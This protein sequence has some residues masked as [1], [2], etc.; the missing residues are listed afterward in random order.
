VLLVE[1]VSVKFSLVPRVRF[2][3]R[4]NLT[5]MLQVEQLDCG[6]VSVQF[7]SCRSSVWSIL[8]AGDDAVKLKAVPGILDPSE[9]LLIVENHVSCVLG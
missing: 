2:P 8:N 3:N 6:I 7:T 1:G 4:L 5:A 9:V